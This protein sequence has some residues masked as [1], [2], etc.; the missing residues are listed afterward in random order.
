M[1]IQ[2][3]NGNPGGAADERGF[4]E[5]YEGRFTISPNYRH[6][7][8]PDSYTVTD[9][10]EKARI[11]FDRVRDCK[12]W[13]ER[14][15]AA[16]NGKPLVTYT[17]ETNPGQWMKV[18]APIDSIDCPVSMVSGLCAHG[19]MAGLCKGESTRCPRCNT[20]HLD[21]IGCPP[22]EVR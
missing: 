4:W 18:G 9:R 5:S 3:V 12:A 7:I 20:T 21:I 22:A 17:P 1:R 6:T 15:I 2:W 13:A 19:L 16:T 8:Y 10:T 11:S 14:Q